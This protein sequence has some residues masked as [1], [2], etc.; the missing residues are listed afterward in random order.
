VAMD[1]STSSTRD[2]R[3]NFKSPSLSSG[4]WFVGFVGIIAAF[5]LAL[6]F[7]QSV[8]RFFFAYLVSFAFFLS[9]SLGGLFFVILQ[10]LT[11]AAWSVNVRRI[12]EWLAASMPILALL[13]TPIAISVLLHRTDLY[14]WAGPPEART[15]E[16][17]KTEGAPAAST[18]AK[19][20]S[21]PDAKPD[22]AA[23]SSD[24]E[25]VNT[26]FKK[27]YLNPKF[28]LLRLVIYFIV[29]SRIGIW[30]WRQSLHQDLTGDDDLTVEMQRRSPVAMIVFAVTLTLAAFDLLMSL[31][32]TWSST[33]FGV[34]YFAGSVIGM[35]ATIII[36]VLVLQKMG[37]LRESITVEHF[38]DLG[39][40]LFGFTFFWGYIGF[41]QYMLMWYANLPEETRWYVHRGASTGKHSFGLTG[42]TAQDLR[43]WS[44]VT[45]ALLFGHLLIP[46]AGLMSRHV[47]RFPPLLAFWAIWLLVF[48]WIDLFWIVM[49]EMDYGTFHFG[50]VEIAAF[51]GIGGMFL[52]F[53]LSRAAQGALRPLHDP[54]LAASL[55]FQNI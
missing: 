34:Y 37:Y 32:P 10:H 26:G 12:P 5:V 39:K 21:N 7:E 2:E 25:D 24:D 22:K 19:A 31:D 47:K 46:F 4:A 45:I 6:I 30:Y 15:A 40:F 55:E 43:P 14:P 16:V 51:L 36:T 20:D 8:K 54:R 17:A 35:F 9:L 48:H 18:E 11:K 28:W 29:W 27:I 50:I 41:S 52:A 23:E 38:H 49:P 42:L 53:V 44:Y 3:L 13:A 1:H 33:I